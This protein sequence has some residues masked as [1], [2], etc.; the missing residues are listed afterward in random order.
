MWQKTQIHHPSD[1]PSAVYTQ[2]TQL[3]APAVHPTL[4]TLIFTFLIKVIVVW[5]ALNQRPASVGGD[6]GK[7]KASLTVMESSE[8]FY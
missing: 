2:Q 6:K 1:D 5:P 3:S 8:G 4:P 7:Y